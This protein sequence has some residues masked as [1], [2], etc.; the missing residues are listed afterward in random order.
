MQQCPFCL[1]VYDESDYA[2]CPYCNKGWGKRK[3]WEDDYYV[4]SD[5]KKDKKDKKRK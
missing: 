4:N 3:N 2:G 5:S 1:K